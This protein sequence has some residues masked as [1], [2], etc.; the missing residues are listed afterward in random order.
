[1]I[2]GKKRTNEKRTNRVPCAI[3]NANSYIE[4]CARW[5]RQM[6]FDFFFSLPFVYVWTPVKNVKW[7][8][9][10]EGR[11]EK[12]RAFCARQVA[13]PGHF[14]YFEDISY[15][16]ELKQAAAG[17]R[18]NIKIQMGKVKISFANWVHDTAWNLKYTVVGILIRAMKVIH[19]SR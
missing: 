16:C 2:E 5:H 3:M 14:T 8:K 19:R 13:T 15:C 17:P 12:R 18:K 11:G 4:L 6:N 1:M 9:K 10:L 7:K